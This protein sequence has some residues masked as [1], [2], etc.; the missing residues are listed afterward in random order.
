M[1]IL[2]RLFASDAKSPAAQ[3]VSVKRTVVGRGLG[4]KKIYYL[5]KMGGFKIQ[6]FLQTQI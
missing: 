6:H 2:I 5:T 1:F 4:F 3:K